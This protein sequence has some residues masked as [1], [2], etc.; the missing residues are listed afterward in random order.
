IDIPALRPGSV[1]G[2]A[3]AVLCTLAALM[4]RL[5]IDPHVVG[6]QYIV[7]FPAVTATTL[8]SGVRAGFVSTALSF[9]AVIFFFLPPRLSFWVEV[10]ARY[11]A[12]AL[13]VLIMISEVLVAAGMR[14]ALERYHELSR[15]LEERVETRTA[16][17]LLRSRQLDAANQRLRQTSDELMAVY[18]QGLYAAH[19]DMD[20][21]VFRATRACVE[22]CGFTPG[23][24]MGKPFWECGWWNKPETQAWVRNGFER[25]ASG[26]PF[27]GEADYVFKNGTEHTAE[28]AFIPIR[29]DSGVA[30]VFV[31]GMDI[32]ERVQ[33]Y[34]AT[35]ENAAVGIAHLN[36]D[37]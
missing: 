24:I 25:A 18:D 8:V 32:T 19:L 29:D 20:G 28:I 30:F 21:K 7:F 27:R 23:E 3:F 22:G 1:G 5:A 17:A 33:Q 11:P 34:R 16:E 15:H 36:P 26:V 4:L 31:P 2:Y 35:F 14:R 37:L 6:A 10:P 13:F 9:A 12:L